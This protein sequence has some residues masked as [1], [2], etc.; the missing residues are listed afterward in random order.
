MPMVVRPSSNLLVNAMGGVIKPGT[1]GDTRLIFCD[2]TLEIAHGG[3]WQAN[4]PES[5][6]DDWGIS[7]AYDYGEIIE[8]WDADFFTKNGTYYMATVDGGTAS[9]S[10]AHMDN[11]WLTD[12][13]LVPEVS[14]TQIWQ[15]IGTF[16]PFSFNNIPHGVEMGAAEEWS[17]GQTYFIGDLIK[18]TVPNGRVYYVTVAGGPTVTEPTWPTAE[19]GTV[20]IDGITYES[21]GYNP[22]A[23]AVPA[24]GGYPEEG[25]VVDIEYCYTAVD[26]HFAIRKIDDGDWAGVSMADVKYA[27]LYDEGTYTDY[28]SVDHINPVLLQIDL[29]S[30]ASSL[31]LV[32]DAPVIQFG[33]PPAGQCSTNYGAAFKVDFYGF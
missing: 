20:S 23:F 4:T 13:S 14:G 10:S 2:S 3:R 17:S 7:S 28:L 32:S 11:Q 30:N 18:P 16:P 27:F 22:G 15:Y 5:P 24:S 1:E 12:G 25:L 33:A 29:D 26:F 19:G 9:T 21:L 8:G 6:Y 31:S